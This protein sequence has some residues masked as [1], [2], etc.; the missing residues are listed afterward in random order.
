MTESQENKKKSLRLGIVPAPHIREALTLP[1]MMW[2]T[3][4]ALLF[5]SAAGVFFFGIQALLL[6]AVCVTAAVL[7]EAAVLKLRN[8]EVK[9]SSGI[10]DGS[11]A[12]TGLLMALILPPSFPLWAGA[13]GSV[14]AIVVVKH[15]SGG[16]GRNIFNPALMGRAVLTAAFPILITTYAIQHRQVT[17]YT[18]V[19]SATPLARAKFEGERLTVR[20]RFV[21]YLIGEKRGS[22]GET[23]P[24]LIII[25]LFVLLYTKTA[26]WRLPSSFFLSVFLFSGL[27][28]IFSP[29][30][31]VNPLLALLT[32]SVFLGGTYMVTDPVTTPVSPSGKM[33][34]GL[35]AGMIVVLIRQLSGYPEG[36]M[37]SILLMNAVT[38]LINRRTAPRVYGT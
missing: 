36:V 6:I 38:P 14:F 7:S 8:S 3:F 10:R 31:S 11:A 25:G 19:S 20:E 1:R 37:F 15:V 5:P 33:I 27:F 21:P 17:G 22:T 26:D 4:L 28:W 32:G 16:L 24:L 23:S 2:Y 12:V 34:F 30:T 35:G 29:E 13:M 18:A 9:K